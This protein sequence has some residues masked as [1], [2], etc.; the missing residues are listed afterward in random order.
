[1]TVVRDRRQDVAMR[2]RHAVRH[3][4]DRMFESVTNREVSPKDRPQAPVRRH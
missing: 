3:A 2:L 4:H 1:M